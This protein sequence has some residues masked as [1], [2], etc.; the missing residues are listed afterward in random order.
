MKKI[1]TN[2]STPSSIANCQ[3]ARPSHLP[4]FCENKIALSLSF[5]KKKNKLHTSYLF[6]TLYRKCSGLK[7]IF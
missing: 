2:K 1:C 6:E 4:S 5:G 3:N 7:I